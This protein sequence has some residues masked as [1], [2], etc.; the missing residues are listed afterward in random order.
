[1]GNVVSKRARILYPITVGIGGAL[2]LGAVYF[3]IVSIAQ[4][5]SH[6]IEQFWQD[7]FIVV[8][9]LSGF[10]VQAA[11]Y[12]I[13]KKRLYVPVTS[14]GSSTRL[15]GAGG[16]TSTIAMVACCAHHVVDVLPF[17]GLTAATAFLAQYRL[18]FLWLGLGTN[19]LGIMVMLSILIKERRRAIQQLTPALDAL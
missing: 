4:G 1:M 10:G 19:V 15:L 5:S 14:S 7:R 16:A 13:I 3:S 6:A 11:L 18:P 8:P 9:I 2:L 17:L 12:V